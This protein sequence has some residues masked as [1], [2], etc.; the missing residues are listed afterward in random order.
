MAAPRS[1]SLRKNGSRLPEQQ[2]PRR[3]DNSRAGDGVLVRKAQAWL[4]LCPFKNPAAEAH[5]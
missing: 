4:K 3:A 1:G 5:Q 2:I